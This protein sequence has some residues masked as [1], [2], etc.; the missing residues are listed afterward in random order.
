MVTATDKVVAPD[1][2]EFQAL[3]KEPSLNQ[4]TTL[5]TLLS[6]LLESNA[7]LAQEVKF[8]R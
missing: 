1:L 3:S 5:C 7:H 8:P 2:T 6:L 4:F